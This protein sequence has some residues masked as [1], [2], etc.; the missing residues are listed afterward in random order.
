MS[1]ADSR[2]RRLRML[3]RV[4]G[5]FLWCLVAVGFFVIWKTS[6]AL[7]NR[8]TV[9]PGPALVVEAAGESNGT[10]D[11]QNPI[12]V[13][14][15][16]GGIESAWSPDG[17]EDFKLTERSGEPVTK[18]DLLGRP[19]AVSFIFTQCAGPCLPLT[20]QMHRIQNEL[21]DDDVRLVTLTVD[22]ERDTPEALT[23]YA[24]AFAA[25]QDAWLFLTGE[26]DEIYELIKESFRMPVKEIPATESRPG[27]EFLH[28]TNIL[29]V[30]AQG[31]VVG[32]YDGQDDAAVA[33]LV[34]A[35]K[36]EAESLKSAGGAGLG[37]DSDVPAVAETPARAADEESPRGE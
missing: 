29:H 35:L 1:D 12:A 18:A 6:R 17:I 31:R 11:N 15:R 37:T 27:F 32:K 4:A 34:R 10:D 24:D 21:K 33:K 2:I 14:P 36:A 9:S 23:K 30:N 16:R 3:L 8:P 22:P 26:R 20:G 5:L 28:T 25:D 19:W 7:E 13:T